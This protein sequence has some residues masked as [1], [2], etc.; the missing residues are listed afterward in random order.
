M[1]VTLAI[2]IALALGAGP[3]AAQ[4][5]TTIPGIP[6]YGTTLPGSGPAN[7]QV[8]DM[9]GNTRVLATAL[10][11]DGSTVAGTHQFYEE[12]Y[13][14]YR[15]CTLLCYGWLGWGGGSQAFVSTGGVTVGLGYPA[16]ATG[17]PL[18]PTGIYDRPGFGTRESIA[19]GISADG[20]TVVG[21]GQTAC[22]GACGFPPEPSSAFI[23][24]AADGLRAIPGFDTTPSS[25]LAT[26]QSTRALGVSGDG[27][28]VVGST[29][30]GD[31]GPAAF[32]WTAPSGTRALAGLGDGPSRALAASFNGSW[33]VGESTVSSS[34]GSFTRATLW[35]P[36]GRAV[37][38]GSVG[39]SPSSFGTDISFDGNVAVGYGFANGGALAFRW[40]RTGG[41]AA[42]GTLAGQD[43]SRATAVSGDGNVVVGDSG[44][45]AGGLP[46]GN[47]FRWTAATGMQSIA[48]W[49][50]GGGV[51]LPPGVVLW[52]ATDTNYNGNVVIGTYRRT[53]LPADLPSEFSYLAR[54]GSAGDGFIAD[55][56]GFRGGVVAS[57]LLTL[58][59]AALLATGAVA[60]A[61]RHGGWNATRTTD[62]R[63]CGWISAS[64]VRYRDEGPDLDTRELGGCVDGGPVRLAL[65]TGRVDTARSGPSGRSDLEGRYT[66]AGVAVPLGRLDASLTGYRGRFDGVVERRYA[67][68]A[69]T[70]VSTAHPDGRFDAAVARLDWTDAL[71]RGRLGLSPY[72]TYAW[73]RTR[74]NS[75]V[76]TGG[77]FPVAYGA[78]SAHV[79][80]LAAGATADLQV[81]SAFSVGAGV[82]VARRRLDTGD[83]IAAR[84]VDLLD[85][86]MPGIRTDAST[87]HAL[88]RMRYALGR[89]LDL[90]A[91]ARAG[92]D[93]DAHDVEA[94][95][96]LRATF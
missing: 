94:G 40:A 92:L 44:F 73:S 83:G 86:S 24:T 9:R 56:D 38:L 59:S 65:G 37:D 4:V 19:T 60:T 14:Y 66:L 57:G 64:R 81:S 88:L 77:G 13:R 50:A 1:P 55:L 91:D 29:A 52:S 11:A 18:N 68:G 31:L 48:A 42:L 58:D 12:Q 82:E 90:Q 3:A 30:V 23:W 61:R 41:I 5:F 33:I 47:P 75:H 43:A 28:T 8:G 22:V 35:G 17:V 32:V 36:D 76:E 7:P 69:G 45:T 62:S 54:I 78:S 26:K 84:V 27:G 34:T 80:E 53:D 87:S 72:L 10:S 85:V 16:N 70:D 71:R 51:G 6:G 74:T 15:G 2:A 20:R 96:Q 49:L 25:G 63:G 46:A 93:R 79:R 21:Y 89:S 39:G 67:N 95:L